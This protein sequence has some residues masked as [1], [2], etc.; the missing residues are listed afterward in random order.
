[1]TL[2]LSIETI[3]EMYKIIRK[4]D[5]DLNQRYNVAPTQD[6][7]IVREDAEGTREITFARWGLI[8]H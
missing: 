1:M 5:R 7:P 3:N 6:I 4:I 8:Q 2:D